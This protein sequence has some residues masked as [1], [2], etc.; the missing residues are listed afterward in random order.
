M[1]TIG[2]ITTP[3]SY[4]TGGSASYNLKGAAEALWE[5]GLDQDALF[6]TMS[7][8]MLSA[9]DR[10]CLSGWGCQVKIYTHDNIITRDLKA[11]TDWIK[12]IHDVFFIYNQS[13]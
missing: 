3:S 11:R 9:V 2:C 7:Q 10:D 6:E 5:P 12:K 8:I 13:T 1:D 4:V